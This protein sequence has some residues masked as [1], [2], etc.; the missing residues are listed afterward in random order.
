MTRLTPAHCALALL[1]L[2]CEKPAPTQPPATQPEPVA[3][4]APSPVQRANLVAREPIGAGVLAAL[5]TNVDPCTDFYQYACG[6]WLRKTPPPA[7]KPRYGRGFG[8]VTDR[9]NE[10]LRA[11]LER[12]AGSKAKSDPVE[13]K[14]GA[15]YAACMD[16]PAIDKA[17]IAP[18]KPL[19]AKVKGVKDANT[20]MTV[21]GGL[22][23]ELFGG[24]GPLFD[25]FVEPDPKR[26]DVYIAFVDQGGTGLP[27]RDFYLKTDER[28]KAL[29]AAYQ[30]HVARMLGFIGDAPDVATDLAAKIVAFETA[31]AELQT[32]RDQMRDPDKI[33]NLLGVEGLAKLDP[34]LNW[35]GFFKSFGYTKLGA[36]VNVTVPGYFEKLGALVRGTDPATLQ[37]YLRW[38]IIRATAGGLSKEIVDA[39]FQFTSALTGAKELSPRWER[40][41]GWAN[42]GLGELVGQAFVK[43]RF[44]GASK[45]I[46]LEMIG[47]I[48][49]AFAAGL[50][51]LAWMDDATRER[52]LDKA[53][54]LH[55]KIGYPDNWRDYGKLKLQR[56]GHASNGF[57]IRKFLLRRDFDRVS[58]P[59][60]KGE[61]HMPPALVNAYY[62]PSANEMVFPAGILQPPY[63]SAE[64]PMA[65]NFGGIGMV[66]GHELSH[67]FDDQG[68]KFDK[69]GVLREWWDPGVAAKFETRAKCIETTYGG[70]EVLPAVKLNGKLTLGENI[71]DFGGI[72]AAYAGYKLHASKK[73]EQ[74]LIQGLTSEQL[75]FIGFAQGWCTH[76]TPES[77]RLRAT[78]D[79]HSPP[80]QRV[81]VPLSHF[82]GFS[83]AFQ[84]QPGAAMRAKDAC[85][86]W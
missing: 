44:A 63:F 6:G 69:D 68:R 77:Q 7:D 14:L 65:M 11:I 74:P 39:D 28:T 22:D 66:M 56:T 82:A 31:L 4:P 61:W 59:V 85:E 75:F 2:A 16:E 73:P 55:N 50:P 1:A 54:A 32:P 46:A 35:A 24:H 67:G 40:C 9:N 19:L 20:M 45:D 79:P 43:E 62:N 13:S 48:E 80:K 38:H 84:C 37:A 53:K 8:E 49:E 23:A 29:L 86:V 70:I 10:V 15:Y 51:A 83:E 72:K 3:A 71:A 33:Y 36:D 58:Q 64:F 27:D 21:V 41:V 25:L 18:I 81:N 52:A 78:V 34:E 26:P 57:A 60:D 30:A 17:G 47:A 12:A 42:M 5:D 76:E